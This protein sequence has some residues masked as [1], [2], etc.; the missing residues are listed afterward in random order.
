MDIQEKFLLQLMEDLSNN[1]VMLPTLPEVALRV[2][3]V[4]ENEKSSTAQVSR[5]LSSDPALCTRLLRVANSA[6][7][8]GRSPAR[9]VSEG[10]S[11]LGMSQIQNIVNALIM[12]QVYQKASLVK[13][14]RPH[15]TRLWMHSTKVAAVSMVLARRYTKLVPEQAMLGGLIHDIG[16][17]P[18]FS[19][20]EAYPELFS[21]PKTLSIVVAELHGDV[22]SIILES[23]NFPQEFAMVASEHD[24][25][26]RDSG[27]LKDLVDVIQVANLL[28]YVGTEHRHTAT[29]WNTVPAFSKLG[30]TP[31]IGVAVLKEAES[32]IR[33][34]QSMLGS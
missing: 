3:R 28:N 30:I 24:D 29:D 13:A 7:Y 2:K 6:L 34:T 23:W 11:R 1:R 22:G 27:P 19:R 26:T 18:I 25:L 10:V 32:E 14:L 16:M 21:N 20:A 31:A 5:M 4:L 8:R 33:E 12:E 15:L 9:N 17:L